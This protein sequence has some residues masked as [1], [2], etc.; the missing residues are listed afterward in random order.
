MQIV[1]HEMKAA[2]AAFL[3]TAIRY[4]KCGLTDVFNEDTFEIATDVLNGLIL[5][6]YEDKGNDV[7]GITIE[8]YLVS[9]VAFGK[10]YILNEE[11]RGEIV[12][13]MWVEKMLH[14]NT[15]ILRKALGF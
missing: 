7:D 6:D 13:Q 15:S 11:V 8:E 3:S 5:T 9:A 4:D 2:F 14:D 12:G 1:E 10:A